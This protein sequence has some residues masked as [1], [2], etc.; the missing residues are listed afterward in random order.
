M[1]EFLGFGLVFSIRRFSVRILSSVRCCVSLMW[2][3]LSSD[4]CGS[5]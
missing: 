1:F 4:E 3:M 5:R 2:S